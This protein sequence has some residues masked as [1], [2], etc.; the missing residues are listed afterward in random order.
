MKIYLYN[1]W[2]QQYINVFKDEEELINFLVNHTRKSCWWESKN[3]YA[4]NE[5][6]DNINMTGNDTFVYHASWNSSEVR[7][8]PYMFVKEDNSIFDARIYWEEVKRRWETR[9]S[10]LWAQSH[11]SEDASYGDKY[12][13]Y[14]RRNGKEEDIFFFRCSPVPGICK[15]SH[16]N[17]FRHPH[18]LNEMR[19]NSDPEYSGYTRPSR[20]CLPTAWDDICRG[21]YKS[22]KHCTKKK[23]QWM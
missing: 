7:L 1:S 18:T 2:K 8:R 11:I 23:K 3:G 10:F 5:Y 22:W 16:G 9:Q 13:R 14:K 20:R 4:R 19:H 6:L 17:W 15:S 12:A 21:H